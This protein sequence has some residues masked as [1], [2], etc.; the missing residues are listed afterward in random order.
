MRNLRPLLFCFVFVIGCSSARV[1][2]P[3]EIETLQTIVAT[4]SFEFTAD[5]ASPM[6]TRS[7]NAVANS[8]L[9]PP[10]SNASRINLVGDSNYLKIEGDSVSANLPYFGER[11]MGGGYGASTGIEF[12]GL[13][14]DYKEHYDSEKNKYTIGFNINNNTEQYTVLMDIFSNLSTTISVVSSSRFSIR[15]DG[16]IK[17]IEMTDIQ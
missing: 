3:S 7:L 8:G 5:S 9:L 15:Y 16:T 13:P 1:A 17:E 2:T 12:D 6:A 11:Q 14:K 4:K 10:G